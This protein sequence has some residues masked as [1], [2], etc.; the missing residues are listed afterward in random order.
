LPIR[1]ISPATLANLEARAVL[2][3]GEFEHFVQEGGMIGFFREDNKV[4]REIN[5]TAAEHAKLKIS[6]RLLAL[7]KT[8]I[9]SPKGTC[10]AVH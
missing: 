9:G 10:N 3:V 1:K 4:R 2:T 8:V 5:L 6:A 7:L